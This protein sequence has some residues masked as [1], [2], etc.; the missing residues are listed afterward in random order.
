MSEDKS[1][2]STATEAS[3]DMTK[4]KPHK[5]ASRWE[6]YYPSSIQEDRHAIHV[7]SFPPI[8]Y[9]WPAILA[10]FFCG[11]AQG[12]G[13]FSESVEGTLGWFA[14]A[15]FAFNI[16]VI[17]QDFDQKKFLILILMI[18]SAGLLVWIIDMKGFEFLRRFARALIE[19]HPTMSTSTYLILAVIL[20]A[21]FLWGM[22]RP[23]FD[24]WVLEHNEFVHYIQPFGRDM[25]VPRMGSTV[26]KDIPDILE[27]ILTCGGG[28]LV[29]KREGEVI[30]TIPHIPFLGRRM[31]V[32]E[33][34][35]SEQRVTTYG[36]DK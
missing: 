11:I 15:V 3:T 25:S 28:S 5:E 32:I 17:V 27:F 34:M 7:A 20:T 8:V 31:K 12:T 33:K 35:L 4:N 19:L 9:F 6:V 26:S 22:I 21:L 10:F 24:Y 18:V 16:L 30:A 23:M 14:I 36:H 29:I 13:L 2:E 1:T